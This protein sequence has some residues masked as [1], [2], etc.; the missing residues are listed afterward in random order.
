V[1]LCMRCVCSFSVLACFLLL[2][3]PYTFVAAYKPISIRRWL[4]V[5]RHFSYILVF[6]SV[7]HDT[8]NHFNRYLNSEIYCGM[9]LAPSQISRLQN[10]PD[11]TKWFCLK[12][13]CVV[14]VCLID[15]I[16]WPDGMVGFD[17]DAINFRS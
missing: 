17:P 7:P 1:A 4:A 12:L 3:L 15:T 6:V 16:N 5:I 10:M 9:F 2:T 11:I 14:L 8:F 13:S